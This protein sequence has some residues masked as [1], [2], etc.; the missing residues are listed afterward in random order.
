MS[1]NSTEWIVQQVDVSV[2][3]DGTSKTHTLLLTSAQID[4]LQHNISAVVLFNLSCP[5]LFTVQ[6]SYLEY[7]AELFEISVS[8]SMDTFKRNSKKNLP[9]A[10]YQ[11]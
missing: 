2:L 4:A 7:V 5:F 10:I 6:A 9:L 3:V 8:L 11:L 1:I